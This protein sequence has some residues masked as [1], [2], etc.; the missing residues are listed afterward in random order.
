M[1]LQAIF[2]FLTRK[3]ILGLGLAIMCTLEIRRGF[4]KLFPEYVRGISWVPFLRLFAAGLLAALALTP[5]DLFL[6]QKAQSLEADGIQRLIRFGAFLGKTH[7]TWGTLAGFYLAGL[8]FR[9]EKIRNFFFAAVL[10]SALTGLM[11]HLIKF[12]AMRA[13]PYQ[14]FGPH[15]FFDVQGILENTRAFQSFPSGDVAITAGAAAFLCLALRR[16][17]FSWIFLLFPVLTALSRMDLNKHWP[18]DTLFAFLLSFPVALFVLQY[19]QY[20]L[21]KTPP[22]TV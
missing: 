16:F 12:A 1:E 8:I 20:R 11:A 21:N 9:S 7:G 14:N 15:H 6:I 4:L 3:Q 18:S 17:Y 10:S 22:G 2:D 19:H 13:R 5:F